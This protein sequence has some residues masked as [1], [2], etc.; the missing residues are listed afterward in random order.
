MHILSKIG[1]RDNVVTYEHI[2]DTAADMAAIEKRYITLGSTCIVLQGEDETMEVY[3]ADSSKEWHNLLTKSDAPAGLALYICTAAEVQDSKPAVEI[4]LEGVMY[5]VPASEESGNLYDEYTY[6]N[7]NWEL[8]GGA[9]I[10]L[11][12]YAT[13]NWVQQQ[14]YL[15]E[16]QDISMKANS[17]DLAAVATSGNYSDLQ[18]TPYIPTKTSDLTNDSNYAADASYVHT[19]NNYT[20]AEKEKL[21]GIAAGAEVNVNA[22]WNAAS[23]KAAILNKPTNVSAFTNDA[24]YLTSHQDIS[25]KAN[26]ADLATVATSGSYSDLSNTP[27]IPT[28]ISDL[29]DDSGHYTK[30]ANGIPASDLAAGVIPDVSIYATKEYVD[31]AT[32][33]M[34]IADSDTMFDE[35]FAGYTYE[36]KGG[37]NVNIMTRSELQIM[38]N[39]IFG[40]D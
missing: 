16:H 24:G 4:P 32:Q 37:N 29:Q 38:L 17:S 23:G 30:P 9:R 14:G 8:F 33:E 19:D 1:N 11:S 6:V 12:T 2:C 26:A 36:E 13:E 40:G 18:N 28:K 22:D 5:L 7:G 31:N 25:G 20:T 35:V 34:T 39:N 10:D 27:A 21:S 15:T 3:M